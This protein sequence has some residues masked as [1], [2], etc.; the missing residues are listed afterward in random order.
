MLLLDVFSLEKEQPPL[1]IVCKLS[2]ELKQQSDR[3]KLSAYESS[4]SCY[5]GS[6][7]IVEIDNY[8]P[9]TRSRRINTCTSDSGEESQRRNHTSIPATPRLPSI[10][11]TRLVSQF[12]SSTI[13]KISN[14]DLIY[15]R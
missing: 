9:Y 5:D 13:F 11:K 2:L 8:R 12:Q 1:F 4:T 15:G 14:G 7:K 6:P 3:K 10:A